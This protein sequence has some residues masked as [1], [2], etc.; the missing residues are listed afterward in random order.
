M[1]RLFLILI[2]AAAAGAQTKTPRKLIASLDGKD[3]YVAYCASCHGSEGKGDGPVAPALKAS[4]PNLRVLAKGNRGVFPRE[5]VEKM[6]LHGATGPHGSAEMPVWGPLF[7]RVQ[8]DQDLGLVRV[9]Q[10][11]EHLKSIQ[12]K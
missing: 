8:N 4:V 9:R 3:L 2:L 6:M 7:R 10:L 5:R 12:D 1:N 11:S